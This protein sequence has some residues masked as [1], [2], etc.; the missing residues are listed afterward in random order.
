MNVLFDHNPVP[1][2]ATFT[3]WDTTSQKYEPASVYDSVSGWSINYELSYGE[4]GLLH[5]PAMFTN[6]FV[7]SVWPG[8][9]SEAPFNPPLISEKGLMLLSCVVPSNATSFEQ[10]VGRDPFENESVTQLDPASQTWSTTTFHDGAWDRGA[11]A[12][13]VAESAFFNLGPTSV[14]PNSQFPVPEPAAWAIMGIGGLLLTG[15]R[16]KL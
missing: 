8:F 2:G 11:P 3:K 5:S 1:D 9:D 14:L 16:R 13:N 12:L 7:G 6:T 10:V 15:L 4:G